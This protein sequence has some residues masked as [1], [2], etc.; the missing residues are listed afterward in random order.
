MKWIKF[1]RIRRTVNF[2]YV[3]LGV[4]VANKFNLKIEML[5]DIMKVYIIFGLI[6]YSGLYGFNSWYEFVFN[7]EDK[8]KLKRTL[9]SGKIDK[10]TALAVVLIL[11]TGSLILGKVF[12][13]PLVKYQFVL[14]LVNIA[15]TVWIKRFN[16]V[17]GSMFIAITG[18][19]RTLVGIVIGGGTIFGFWY[20][21]LVHYLVST[22]FHLLKFRSNNKVNKSTFVILEIFLLGLSGLVAI[23]LAYYNNYYPLLFWLPVVTN[24]MLFSNDD[25][26]RR[27]L[28]H[29]WSLE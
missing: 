11:I 4:V 14:L 1:F 12:L 13:S 20:L 5:M 27:K 10:N 16:V 22:S 25:S 18:P 9:S 3:I 24:L 28:E 29:D 26:Y 15:Y 6:M 8:N 23:G 17:L 7:I 21:I 19:T 2:L